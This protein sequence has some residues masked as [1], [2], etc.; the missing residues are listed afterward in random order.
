M[1]I[2]AS[3]FVQPKRELKKKIKV[4]KIVNYL[5]EELKDF[6]PAELQEYRLN[7]EFIKYVCNLVETKIS[8]KYKPNKKEI[9]LGILLKLIPTITEPDKKQIS[10]NIEFLHGNGDIKTITILRYFGRTLYS[11]LKKKLLK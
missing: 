1:Y 8:K 9:V 4:N 11:V 3:D 10:E 2:M 7:P 5:K 6:S